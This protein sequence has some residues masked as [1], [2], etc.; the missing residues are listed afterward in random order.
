M[1]DKH[2]IE[3]DTSV[4]P[5]F[6]NSIVLEGTKIKWHGSFDELKLFVESHLNL[7]GKWSSPG[8]S[9]KQFNS[10]QVMIKYSKQSSI[11][12]LEGEASEKVKQLLANL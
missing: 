12:S 7:K 4:H 2:V 1:A 11:L 10:E 8:G 6:L 3:S 9:T 5:V